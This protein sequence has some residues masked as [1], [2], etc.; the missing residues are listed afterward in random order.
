MKFNFFLS[1]PGIPFQHDIFKRHCFQLATNA[2]ETVMALKRIILN[3]TFLKGE[4]K[5]LN[6]MN[7]YSWGL[8]RL[9]HISV[10]K[11]SF[12]ISVTPSLKMYKSAK[13]RGKIIAK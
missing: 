5:I 4:N 11:I 13:L 7:P 10:P 8:G 9:F 12:N 1:F 3:C 6:V 2:E